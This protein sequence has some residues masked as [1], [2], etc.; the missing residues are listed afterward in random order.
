MYYAICAENMFVTKETK[1]K[2]HATLN[3]KYGAK[4]DLSFF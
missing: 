4:V 2:L 1:N 3:I